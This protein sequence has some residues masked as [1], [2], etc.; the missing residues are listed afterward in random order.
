MVLDVLE[1]LDHMMRGTNED[2]VLLVSEAYRRGASWTEIARRLGRSKQTVHQRYQPW[3]HAKGTEELLQSDL[4]QAERRARYICHHGT[5]RDEMV[6]ARAFLRQ[7]T[8]QW[9]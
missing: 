9:P 5:D 6:R 3:V 4:A 7:R 8:H 1:R 2:V